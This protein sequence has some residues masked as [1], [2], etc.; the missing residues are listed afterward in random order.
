[1]ASAE[2]LWQCVRR[3]SCFL[4]KSHGI[5]LS[6][7]PL[8]LA[9]K[10]SL[11]FSGLCHPRPLGLQLVGNAAAVKLSYRAKNPN[12]ARFPRR[13]L[14]SKKF[15]KSHSKTKQLLQLVAQQ[16]PDLVRLAKKRFHK[17]C[18]TSPKPA[19]AEQQ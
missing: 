18:K 19:Q 12:K 4:R 10:N 9:Q 3:T 13:A 7:E 11:R 14:C 1:M 16:R 5:L 15:P 6:K 8:N 17:L 2:L